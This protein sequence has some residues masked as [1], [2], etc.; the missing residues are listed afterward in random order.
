MR[1]PIGLSTSL[2]VY[3]LRKRLAREPFVPLVLMLEPLFACNLSCSTC[4]RIREYKHRASEMMTVDECIQSSQECGAPIV[5][6]C[7]GEPLIYP[8][9]AELVTSLVEMGKY[10]YLCTNGV[11]LANAL[12]AFKPS[13]RLQI[14]VHIDGPPEIHDRVVEKDG[15]YEDAF[16]GI[17]MASRRGFQ[18]TVNTTVCKQTNMNQIDA[19]MDKLSQVGVR[20]FMLSPAYSYDSVE[21]KDCFMD[22]DDVRE[23][24]K[25]ID[26]IA[27]RH[28]L[29]DT[30][31]YLEYLKG[32]RE[33]ECTAWGNPTRNVAGWRSP[34][35]LVADQHYSRYKDL[36]EKTDWSSY[37]VGRDPR[38]RNCMVHCGFE[39]TAALMVN[40][41][42][43]D[44]WKMMKWQLGR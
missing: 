4:G 25:D 3:I 32:Q 7:G 13:S 40:K 43:G 6:I 12:S 36:I 18:V 14:N 37:G 27:S 1:F 16:K 11:R 31:I 19:L 33:L 34:C 24:F 2:A 9:I 44:L 10:V 21:S 28:R 30:P 26:T 29:A 20:T 17:M 5:S 42:P 39:P 41:Q 35:Y 22:R 15:A 38:C 8:H 23:K